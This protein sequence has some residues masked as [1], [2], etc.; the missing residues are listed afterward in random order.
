M[1]LAKKKN[2]NNVYS[3]IF[4]IYRI[5]N[6]NRLKPVETIIDWFILHRIDS[7]VI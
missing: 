3:H 7:V 5:N 1:I 2:L 6:N 4:E